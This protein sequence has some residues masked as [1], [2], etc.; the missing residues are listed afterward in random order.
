MAIKTVALDRHRHAR[1]KREAWKTGLKIA[2]I[3][4]QAID[5]RLPP[6]ENNQPARCTDKPPKR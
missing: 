6:T 2:A 4:A 3:V 5:L 1:V